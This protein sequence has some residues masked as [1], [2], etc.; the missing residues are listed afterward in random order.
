MVGGANRKKS[1]S[2]SW[3]G[4]NQLAVFACDSETIDFTTGM[5]FVNLFCSLADSSESEAERQRS[6]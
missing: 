4:R 3:P 5:R 1:C 6:V 2:R